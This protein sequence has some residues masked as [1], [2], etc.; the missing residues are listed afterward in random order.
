[1]R[2]T[3]RI[4]VASLL[5]GCILS[6]TACGRTFFEGSSVP[7]PMHSNP[8]EKT[9]SLGDID[10][11]FIS[12]DYCIDIVNTDG[13]DTLY[14]EGPTE[15]LAAVKVQAIKN[16]VNISF[17]KAFEPQLARKIHLILSLKS[18][19]QL[20]YEGNGIVMGKKLQSDAL[21]LV[22]K[23]NGNVDLNGSLRLHSVQHDGAGELKVAG[24]SGENIH[25]N[26]V[27]SGDVIL[28]GAIGMAELNY[29]GSGHVKI[30]K[31]TKELLTINVDGSGLVELEGV[32]K[33]KSITQKGSA[34]LKLYWIDNDRLSIT[35]GD[36]ST[37][38]LAG[39]VKWL[40]L[41]TDSTAQFN[42]RYLRTENAFVRAKDNSSAKV[43]VNQQ[44]YSDASANANIYAYGRPENKAFTEHELGNVFPM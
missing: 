2:G 31:L 43:N 41:T 20:V 44:L 39:V 36:K 38:E 19:C 7:A 22:T 8:T 33:L 28:E 29:Q 42:G 15:L 27:G 3:Y 13:P 40:Y 4:L 14:L 25:F 11:A 26:T 16:K 23:G 1:M 32:I 34:H 5:A 6:L 17:D 9:I 37:M 21:T 24:A 10:R 12:G 18:L 35:L 30:N